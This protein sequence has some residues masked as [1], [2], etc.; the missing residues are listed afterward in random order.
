MKTFPIS[1]TH[2]LVMVMVDL[3]VG[4]DVQRCGPPLIANVTTQMRVDIT[5]NSYHLATLMTVMIVH[6]CLTLVVAC[7]ILGGEE[8]T[9]EGEREHNQQ[10]RSTSILLMYQDQIAILRSFSL[11]V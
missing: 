6:A 10:G 11:S 7:Q 8:E 3:L 4:M 9:V 2:Y 1:D 5:L